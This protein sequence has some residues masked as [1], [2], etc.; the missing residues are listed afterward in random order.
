VVVDVPLFQKSV[1]LE[2]RQPQQ[3]TGFKVTQR[4]RAVALDGESFERVA[5]WVG[6]LGE[7]VGKL[8]GDLHGLRVAN[9]LVEYHP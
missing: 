4:L 6:V 7:V 2:A 3:L 5:P 9:R 1:E 8:D